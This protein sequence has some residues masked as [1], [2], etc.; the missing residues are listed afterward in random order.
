M[1]SMPDTLTCSQTTV[2]LNASLTMA[3][4]TVQWTTTDGSI[5]GG[6]NTLN[7][8][9]NAPGTYRITI[10][11]MNGCTAFDEVYVPQNIKAPFAEAGATQ[12]I[13]LSL[14]HI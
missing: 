3:N 1:I 5:I 4:A 10:V 6:V 13:N 9:V 11:G 14:I 7:P 12:V 2:T 8:T